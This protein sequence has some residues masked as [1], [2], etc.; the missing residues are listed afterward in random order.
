[1]KFHGTKILLFIIFLCAIYSCSTTKKVPEGE[2]LLTKNKFEFETKEKPF[3]GELQDYVKQRPNG[4]V[5]FGLFPLKLMI[6]NWVPAK[7][8]TTFVEYYDLTSKKR[9]QRA[10]DSLLVKNGL[11]EYQGRSLWLKRFLFNQGEP[12]VLIDSALTTFSEENLEQFYFDRGYFDAHISS[13]HQLDSAA[14]KGSVHYKINPG[15]MS[16]I[17]SYQYSISDTTIQKHYETLL[18]RGNEIKVG[19]RYDIQNFIAERDRIVEYLKNR[20]YYRFNDDGQAIE[21][22]ADTT[23][24]DKRLDVTLLIPK[25]TDDSAHVKRKFAKYRYGEIHI[26]P[27]SNYDKNDNATVYYDT[28]Y[29]GYHFHYL[30]PKMKYRPKFFADALVIR[31]GG[32]YRL[33]SEQ[34]TK[35][36]IFKREG[37]SLTGYL[38]VW[39]KENPNLI[40]GDSILNVFISFRP[41]KKY[42]LFYGAELSWSEFMNFGVSPKVSFIARNLFRGGENLEASVRG[43]L[44]NVNKK[45]TDEKSFFNAFEMA[46]QAKIAFPYL[47]FPINTDN[48]FPKRFYKQSDVRIGAAVQRNIGLGRVNY[49]SGIDYNISFRDTQTHMVS[50]L[51]NEFVNNLQQDN[52]FNV[53]GGDKAIMDNFLNYYYFPYNPGAAIQHFNGEISDDQVINMAINDTDFQN[54]LTEQGREDFSIF[55]NMNFRK[56]TITQNVFISSMIYQFTLNQSG[57]PNVKNPWY[58]R[59]RVE[60]A[61]N[62]L[63]LLD[64]S[65]GFFKTTTDQ[66]K[67][68]GAVFNV[69][70]SQFIKLDLDIR[71]YFNF[72]SRTSLATRAFFGIVQPYGNSDFVPFVRSYTAGGANDI[73]AWAAATLG[74]ADIP[75]YAGGDDVFAIEQMKLLFSAEYRFYMIGRFN[76]ALFVD[77]GNIWGTDK[78]N[79]LTL[80]KFKDFYKE[81]GVGAGFGLRLDLTFLLARLDFAYKIHDPSYPLGDRWRFNDFNLFNPRIAFGINYPF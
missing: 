43:T 65:F 34:Q 9:T 10:L 46:F 79:E 73:R 71:K 32:L 35:R 18:Q 61:G 59:G 29:D 8:D 48:L 33:N 3:K 40:Q 45:F 60:L 63:N 39:D 21:F 31:E 64:K 54:T 22:T 27:E 53:F 13:D 68:Y 20:G 44:G 56:Q 78:E 12:P 74:P 23:E 24:T 51:N 62:I 17:N 66:G 72:N 38:P 4:G 69:P 36:N 67:E 26:Y 28:I 19:K 52:Y 7:F 80:F 81:L 41:K 16:V 70:Y 5:L 42:D 49:T 6:Y 57:R 30:D 77:A 58:F 75:R 11:G 25:E 37:V 76:G 50:I 55:Q 14:K 1:M 2:Y 47:V 15:E